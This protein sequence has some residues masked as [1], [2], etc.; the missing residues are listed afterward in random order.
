M[1]AWS[2]WILLLG[3]LLSSAALG[4]SGDP[5]RLEWG[6]VSWA[7]GR[8]YGSDGGKN[9]V[10]LVLDEEL[11]SELRRLLV[12][13]K[14]TAAAAVVVD[15]ET[16][17]VLAA[18]ELGESSGS[19]LFDPVAPAASVFK[20]VTTA[21]LYERTG[22]T[23][24]TRVCTAGGLRSIERS[25]LAPAEGTGT[26]CGPFQQALG[27]SRNAAFAQL[28]NQ[29]L[30][31]DDLRGVAE[32]LG[33]N[34]ELSLDVRGRVG[35]LSLPYNDLE[36]ARAAAGFSNSRLSVFGGAQL[37]LTVASGG[38]LVPMHFRADRPPGAPLRVLS[39]RTASRLVRAM[40][41]TVHSG[42]ARES[43]VDARGHGTLG[44][45][46]AAGKTGTLKPE[47]SG[48]TSSWFVG[49]APSRAPRVAI[50]VLLQNPDQW[51]KKA[52]KVA[53]DLFAYYFSERGVAIATPH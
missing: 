21:A 14:S 11:Q 4:S 20:L 36:F 33:F 37:A 40:E 29:E 51:H 49:F 30:M 23:P 16:G 50:A 26:V 41:V 15:V 18:T 34:R 44:P 46:Q 43:F 42:T 52:H 17:A 6:T 3:V 22:V 9:P 1:R 2:L 38:L 31:R 35:T 7:E 53:R 5:H 25:H 32:A 13:A 19:L 39:E 48:P 45:I 24:S 10:P 28:A 27:T 12:D 8:A 47:E